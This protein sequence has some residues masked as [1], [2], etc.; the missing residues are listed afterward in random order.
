MYYIAFSL[1]TIAGFI[2]A[3]RLALGPTAPDRVVAIDALSS[4]VIASIV[5]LSLMLSNFIFIDI[6]IV[7]AMF[8]FVGTLAISKYLMGKGMQEG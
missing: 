1:V 5:L 8:A 2:S 6:A 4:L 3:V 7:Y